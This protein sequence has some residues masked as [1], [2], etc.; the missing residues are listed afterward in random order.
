MILSEMMA[1][2]VAQLLSCSCAHDN[3]SRNSRLEL[4]HYERATRSACGSMSTFVSNRSD[5]TT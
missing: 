5:A 4:N 3:F 1:L 2:Q